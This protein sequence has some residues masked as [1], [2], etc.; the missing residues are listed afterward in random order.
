MALGSTQPL[1]KMSTR[2]K[3]NQY[4]RLTTSP[5]SCAECH[6]IWEPKPPGTLWTTPRLLQDSFTFYLYKL[7]LQQFLMLLCCSLITFH[8]K[9]IFQFARL[10]LTTQQH[11]YI[12]PVEITYNAR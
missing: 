7:Q 4:I 6:G 10:A 5:S 2:V 3:G 9:F 1:V 12:I 11:K 8:V